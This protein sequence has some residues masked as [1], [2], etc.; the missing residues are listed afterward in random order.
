MLFSLLCALLAKDTYEGKQHRTY[1]QELH[2]NTDMPMPQG[3]FTCK[4]VM[5]VIRADTSGSVARVTR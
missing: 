4:S 2:D 3:R 1:I 5:G